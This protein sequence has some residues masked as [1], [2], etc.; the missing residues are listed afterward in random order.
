M[1]TRPRRSGY[2]DL[3]LK[4]LL[5]VG[6]L[7]LFT[8]AF[9]LGHSS[10]DPNTQNLEQRLNL[11]RGR[12]H[13]C[14]RDL[15]R[16]R[17]ALSKNELCS[18]QHLELELASYVRENEK[19]QR[20]NFLLQEA[21]ESLKTE[22]LSLIEDVQELRVK[23]EDEDF[24]SD[25]FTMQSLLNLTDDGFQTRNFK[26]SQVIEQLIAEVKHSRRQTA[27]LLT[28]LSKFSLESFSAPESPRTPQLRGSRNTYDKIKDPL[29]QNGAA[30]LSRKKLAKQIEILGVRLKQHWRRPKHDSNTT[31]HHGDSPP[32]L[33]TVIR[34][35]PT[36]DHGKPATG[37]PTGSKPPLP[38]P[39]SV[40]KPANTEP[41]A[42]TGSVL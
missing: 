22:K 28:E 23:L 38:D 10:Q 1:Q 4:C 2:G 27:S 12:H 26:K 41:I 30:L 35:K 29:Q 24:V 3:I 17:L 5:G 15:Q 6:A 11:V 39:V 33:D 18:N 9:I 31:D 25:N 19:L 13:D 14:H 7:L 37:T 20:E 21:A 42:R 34:Q 36:V 32:P 16:V 40:A 8:A